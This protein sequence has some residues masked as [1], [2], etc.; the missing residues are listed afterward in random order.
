[1]DVTIGINDYFTKPSDQWIHVLMHV[2][3]GV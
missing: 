3:F 2:W 1:M